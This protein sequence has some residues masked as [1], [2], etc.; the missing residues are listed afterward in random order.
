MKDRISVEVVNSLVQAELG[1]RAPFTKAVG[2][3]SPETYLLRL[4]SSKAL[5]DLASKPKH[6]E[7]TSLEWTARWLHEQLYVADAATVTRLLLDDS[8]AL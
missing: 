1:A 3:P 4:D 6:S 8:S 2:P 7:R 5:Q